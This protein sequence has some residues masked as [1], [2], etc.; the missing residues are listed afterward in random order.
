MMTKRALLLGFLFPSL[1]L[2]GCG[3]VVVPPG[4][5]GSA[6]GDTE[7]GED[8][9]SMEPP[10]ATTAMTNA[11]TTSPPTTSPPGDVSGGSVDTGVLDTGE[12]PEDCSLFAQDCPAGY[13]CMPY[14]N[15]GG[16]TWN[17]TVCVP[18]VDEPR[19]VGESCMLE[20][21]ELNGLDDCDG[22]SMC[23]DVDLET[24]EGTCV[25]FCIGDES[26]P[27]C[28]DSCDRCAI[29]GDGVLTLCLPTCDPVA[30]NCPEGEGCY[31]LSGYFG[32]APDAS[33]P[34]VGVGSPC[35]FINGCPAGLLC[36]ES[37]YLPDCQ[38][39]LGCCTPTC[40]VGG[41][42]PCPA[43]VPGTVCTPWYGEPPPLD[44]CVASEPGA[45]AIP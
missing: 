43:L 37:F 6:T 39:A 42:D 13:K 17:D 19:A 35:E 4:S 20:S 16:N 26:E 9:R 7:P 24:L 11:V 30:Q 40:A 21:S 1:V 14:A 36:V 15:D 44:R 28:A 27:A 5:D 32:C 23:W 22:T 25:P 29:T 31:P 34:G 10:P 18:L 45:C 33:M 38:G 12:F 8:T 3:P 41:F 2:A